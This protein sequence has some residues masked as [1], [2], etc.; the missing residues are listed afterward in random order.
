MSSSSPD[1]PRGANADKLFVDA[2]RS[3]AAS[4]STVYEG[5]RAVQE[6]L[7]FHF[8]RYVCMYTVCILGGKYSGHTRTR[9]ELV[10]VAVTRG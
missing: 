8:G 10:V 1:P 9:V 7:Q 6:Y 5:E 4:G 3:T 2:S